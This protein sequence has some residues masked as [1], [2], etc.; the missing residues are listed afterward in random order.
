MLLIV[1]LGMGRNILAYAGSG[2]LCDTVI[3]RFTY[4]QSVVEGM[5]DVK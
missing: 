3:L 4:G 1:M 5:V 2:V